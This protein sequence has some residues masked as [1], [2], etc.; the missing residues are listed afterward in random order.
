MVRVTA[1]RLCGKAGV[2]TGA[3]G[4]VGRGIALA[5]ARAGAD[6]IVAALRPE[7]GDAVAAQ[8]NDLAGNGHGEA[9]A[10]RCDVTRRA[11]LV[12]AVAASVDAFDH[13][14]FLIHNATSR[15]SPEVHG[16]EDASP[17]L[18][19]EHCS[20]SLRGS[21][22]AAQAALPELQ[23][24]RG[25]LVLLT[26]P[27]GIEGSAARPLYAAVKA[28]QRALVKSLAQEWGPLGVRV[29]AVSPLAETPALATAIRENP[30]LRDQLE[31]ITPLGRIGEP[32]RDIGAAVA[33]LL[34]DD[35]GYVTGQTWVIDGG[36]FTGL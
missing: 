12:D 18:W 11:D 23:R 22:F 29:N 20:V 14:S 21:Y 31:A 2:V 17:E 16:L 32:E 30:G 15:R 35:A 5:L 34:D 28:G 13:C 36:R 7:M 1:S 4:G 19:E 3:G 33:L 25:Q 10:V 9:R 24:N 6:V 8:I 26:S 27:A